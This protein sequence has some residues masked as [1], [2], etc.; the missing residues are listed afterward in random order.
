M[1][2]FGCNK[3]GVYPKRPGGKA[4]VVRLTFC[5]VV[6]LS[7]QRHMTSAPVATSTEW[8]YR[9]KFEWKRRCL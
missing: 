2:T 6:N 4:R 8:V 9:R 3:V 7:T 5:S 1:N